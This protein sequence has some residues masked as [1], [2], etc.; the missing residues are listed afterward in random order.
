MEICE[1]CG[2]EI[3]IKTKYRKAKPFGE[4][5]KDVEYKCQNCGCREG[6]SYK[7]KSPSRYEIR[8]IRGLLELNI[9]KNELT[10]EL[11]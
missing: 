2:G 7:I 3:I 1:L 10:K 4:V 9:L 8:M 11:I 5:Y 6:N